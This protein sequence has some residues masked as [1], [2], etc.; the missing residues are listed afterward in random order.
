M[1]LYVH[2]I[3][4][5]YSFKWNL[6]L[7]P[8]IIYLRLIFHLA[9]MILIIYLTQLIFLSRACM[10]FN[11]KMDADIWYICATDYELD[12]ILVIYASLHPLFFMKT[13]FKMAWAVLVL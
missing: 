7:S 8:Y 4:K 10:A 3:F 6:Y 2:Y 12:W 11:F 9:P 13:Q 5:S 1:Q